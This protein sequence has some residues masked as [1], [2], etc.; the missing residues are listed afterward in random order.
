MLAPM[1]T[2]NIDALLVA[3]GRK[4]SEDDRYAARE[5]LVALALTPGEQQMSARLA[6]RTLGV[7][8]DDAPQGVR[9]SVARL[10]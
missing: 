3:C 6:L 4:R 7:Y 9:F 5:K 1:V 8:V 2:A 10:Q